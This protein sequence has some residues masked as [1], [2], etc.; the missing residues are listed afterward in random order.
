[1]RTHRSTDPAAYRQ[2]V[3][4]FGKPH[5]VESQSGAALVLVAVS[6]V[7][8]MGVVALAVDIGLLFHVRTKLQ[9]TADAAALA[10]APE[11]PSEFDA[12]LVAREYVGLNEAGDDAVLKDESVVLGNWDAGN[13]QFTP[14]GNPL[15]AVEVTVER[16]QGNEN[17]VP[18]W[19]ARVLGINDAD[20]SATAIAAIGGGP[21][22]RFLIDDEMIDKDIPVIEA[23]AAEYGVSP[24]DLISDGDGDWFI[25]LPP[26]EILELPTGQVGD[27]GLF[28][29][30]HPEFPF[31]QTSNPSHPDFL[32]FNEDGSWRQGLVPKKKLDPLIGVS[33]VDDPSR[34][35]SYVSDECS[36]VSPVY[37]SDIS[38]LNPVNGT[39]AVNALGMRR[40]LLAFAIVDVGIDPD[41]PSGS[42]LPN[43]IIRVCDPTE[44]DLVGPGSGGGGLRLVR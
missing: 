4:I 7:A 16:T 2:R 11:I 21:G 5:A 28:D 15:N 40:G 29:I 35:P 13:K 8:L 33:R 37:K 14:D 18:L 6:L 22:T 41:G 32:N 42:V 38:A 27:E 36:H 31:S 24:E 19:F 30:N 25:D 17:P 34:Y 39:P 1:M 20:V 23:L 3:V 10:A 9:A 43:L 12:R 44:I 26:G